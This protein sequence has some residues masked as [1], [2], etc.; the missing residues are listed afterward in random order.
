ML[1]RLASS[2]LSMI[3]LICMLP[4]LDLVTKAAYYPEGWETWGQWEEPWGNIIMRP[5]YDTIRQSGC[6]VSSYA[7]MYIQAG[8]V[9]DSET[10]YNLG[11]FMNWASDHNVLDYSSCITGAGFNMLRC[12]PN[13][14]TSNPTF[15]EPA[16]PYGTSLWQGLAGRYSLEGWS[17]PDIVKRL[18][19]LRNE[20]YMIIVRLHSNGHSVLIG[21]PFIN[22]N[23]QADIEILDTGWS[24]GC[25]NFLTD[26]YRVDTVNYYTLFKRAD[27]KPVYPG[28]KLDV[29]ESQLK[30]DSAVQQ[31]AEDN[32]PL[33][34]ISNYNEEQKE[35]LAL[36]QNKAMNSYEIAAWKWNM[37]VSQF[38]IPYINSLSET[39]TADA[40]A[41]IYKSIQDA[42][43]DENPYLKSGTVEVS[44][45]FKI[46]AKQYLEYLKTNSGKLNEVLRLLA[47]EENN[48]Y[49]PLWSE[50][51]TA[52]TVEDLLY[53]NVLY[54]RDNVTITGSALQTCQT[55]SGED[56]I[57]VDNQ[58]DEDGDLEN[59]SGVSTSGNI[60]LWTGL[61][62]MYSIS[63]GDARTAYK[64][65]LEQSTVETVNIPV[66]T[67]TDSTMLYNT[68]FISNAMEFQGDIYGRDAT[69]ENF[70]NDY[71]DKAVF[72]DRWGNITIKDSNNKNIIVYPS[73]ANPLFVSTELSDNDIAGVYYE[74]LGNQF[75]TQDLTLA[76]GKNLN[77][78]MSSDDKIQMT[79]KDAVKHIK[80]Y[81]IENDDSYVGGNKDA[82]KVTVAL[83]TGGNDT[84]LMEY[85]R[86]EGVVNL[87]KK[88]PPFYRFDTTTLAFANKVLLTMMTRDSGTAS[89]SNWYKELSSPKF[90]GTIESK[91]L[92]DIIAS[93]H[94]SAGKLTV[95]RFGTH[96]GLYATKAG[97]STS[98]ISVNGNIYSLI[99]GGNIVVLS[100]W[101][102][103][104]NV[105]EPYFET[106]KATKTL[107][108]SG[109]VVGY[110][111]TI[112]NIGLGSTIISPA[113]YPF[114]N[115]YNG[116]KNIFKTNYGK[117]SIRPG[118]FIATKK[119]ASEK[120][121]SSN[122]KYRSTYDISTD[123][124]YTDVNMYENIIALEYLD[125]ERYNLYFTTNTDLSTDLS[126]QGV[127]KNTKRN[128]R[129]TYGTY[130]NDITN[131]SLAAGVNSPLNKSEIERRRLL[132]IPI[133]ATTVDDTSSWG[134][135]SG[136]SGNIA[137]DRNVDTSYL[138]SK[139]ILYPTYQE[140]S[141]TIGE[142]NYNTSGLKYLLA[143][144]VVSSTFIDPPIED[145]ISIAYIWDT[146]YIPN[147]PICTKL[148]TKGVET[149]TSLYEDN[150]VLTPY[151]GIHSDNNNCL[152]WT[153]E[154]N[155]SISM[156][157][158]NITKAMTL[159]S[160]K[161]KFSRE[162]YQV[163]INY[164]TFVMAI[165]KNGYGTN[166]DRWVDELKDPASTSTYVMDL[167]GAF[168]KSPITGMRNLFLGLSQ[169][170][171][172]LLSKGSVGSV[173]NIETL[174][175]ILWSK[176]GTKYFIIAYGIFISIG[177]VIVGL[178]YMIAH[179]KK[180]L[181]RKWTRIIAIGV[182]PFILISQ[183]GLLFEWVTNKMLTPVVNKI[184]LTELEG[185]KRGQSKIQ[186]GADNAIMLDN[187]LYN[188]ETFADLSIEL[189][190]DIDPSGN[191][192]YTEVSL[193]DLYQSV[194]F[195][196]WVGQAN[197]LGLESSFNGYSK[198][199]SQ[200]WYN[201]EEFVPV[202]YE[203]YKDSVFYY[204]Y[205]WIKSN[206]IRYY[207]KTG[208]N[209]L[210]GYAK[211]TKGE[212][213]AYAN[214]IQQAEKNY[215][216]YAEGMLKMYTDE[217]YIR[218]NNG[219]TDIFGLSNLFKMTTEYGLPCDTY[220]SDQAIENWA[221]TEYT[222][223]VSRLT[224]FE[225]CKQNITDSV[226]VSPIAAII[227]SAYWKQYKDSLYLRG[228][229]TDIMNKYSFTPD[230]LQS[231]LNY[232]NTYDF[233]TGW[234][235]NGYLVQVTANE[236][237]PWRVYG[238]EALLAH[239]AG[240]IKSENTSPTVLESKL[241]QLNEDMYEQVLNLC[242]IYEEG[243]ITDDTMIFTFALLATFEFNRAFGGDTTSLNLSTVSTDK[244]FRVI[245]ATEIEQVIDNPNLVY[246]VYETGGILTAI[247]FVITELLF[248]ITMYMRCAIY[249]ITILACVVA[250]FS[251]CFLREEKLTQV[252][253]GLLLQIGVLVLGQFVVIALLRIG[254]PV[255]ATTDGKGRLFVVT[256]IYAIVLFALCKWHYIMFKSLVKSL[257]NFGYSVIKGELVGL[258]SIINKAKMTVSRAR[259][260][261]VYGIGKCN[262]K[263]RYTSND[264]VDE[265]LKKKRS[266]NAMKLNLEDDD[267]DIEEAS[268]E[269]K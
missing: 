31:S 248:I 143:N 112:G 167:I 264:I 225:K 156:E 74:Q 9:P 152:F 38:S 105:I 47:N 205:D 258:M 22:E 118:N 25:R 123:Q 244:L 231:T 34:R 235:N 233:N 243:H 192:T 98:G 128:T 237:T 49:T 29:S 92:I 94:S 104:G 173:F 261:K 165:N 145:I 185:A 35:S 99:N 184:I 88:A 204:F 216:S 19:E 90:E 122:Y 135:W 183:V 5:G 78:L 75:T 106:S 133:L 113:D 52:A 46:A 172:G 194:S 137:K 211:P 188:Q 217:S 218:L 220:S 93:S 20:G 191:K 40:W 215:M 140:T 198:D 256:V 232:T 257:R 26:N 138:V 199:S 134:M 132:S 149:E 162:I 80:D 161:Y 144:E 178:R 43:F 95:E 155:G 201:T 73:Y 176:T 263:N 37:I 116:I 59:L 71:K 72:M 108:S 12:W 239:D 82:F 83:D 136:G 146:Y 65:I 53:G 249:L 230:Y 197:Y 23:G 114:M 10:G 63:N 229:D 58:A 226:T 100:K 60:A 195:N 33:Y 14:D 30:L 222:M 84:S 234:V 36:L 127:S 180:G 62:K 41:K 240:S 182:I 67:A 251:E 193:S 177:L 86:I 6:W 16:D 246:M 54:I 153:R 186:L 44:E 212:H 103:K 109:A 219:Y 66:F 266:I 200:I 64:S 61:E 96:V 157:L 125:S 254:L 253:K 223:G 174:F 247:L 115:Y 168:L 158:Q 21:D 15:I 250:C 227:N 24:S 154:T 214:T 50:D 48:V 2:V 259:I 107:E 203:K 148:D 4:P 39:L 269:N 241:F 147:S 245:Y 69:T 190:T 179:I 18:S 160:S 91:S 102:Q 209:T 202:H 42:K 236:R 170:I 255:I 56:E 81:A 45:E 101:R 120:A 268:E 77:F 85:N 111:R 55:T 51:N 131:S 224:D 181:F 265:M 242:K 121:I 89:S 267:S 126:I 262:D 139:G 79:L 206:Y 228:K 171:H 175:N 166:L 159:M 27:G 252:L 142:L 76:S 187:L 260:D 130:V 141:D 11:T 213:V 110:A 238:S 70:V 189:L 164:P 28:E 3:L 163:N 150:T 97:A 1:K 208:S 68:L 7:K 17:H 32:S 117:G 207:S 151:N 87:S 196:S 221:A 13:G 210:N 124:E 119:Y 57:E 169:Y 8:F 129:A